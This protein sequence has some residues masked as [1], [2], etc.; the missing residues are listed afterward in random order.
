MYNMRIIYNKLFPTH[1]LPTGLI[2]CFT[3]TLPVSI[4]A[5]LNEA[6]LAVFCYL[7]IE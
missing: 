1:F 6:F 3:T 2:L 7:I 5:R 4:Q